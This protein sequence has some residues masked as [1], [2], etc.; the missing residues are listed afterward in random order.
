M[1]EAA[2]ALIDAESG[3]HQLATVVDGERLLVDPADIED[4]TGWVLK[5]EGLCR[6]DVCVPVREPQA[7][8]VDGRIDLLGLASAVRVPLVVDVDERVV[9]IGHPDAAGA[10][11]L[12]TAPDFELPD[13]D[14]NPVRLSSLG[15]GKKKILVT[16][17]SWCGCRHDLPAWEE[18]RRELEPEGLEIVSVA[19]DD[20]AD[21]ARTYVEMA[22]PAPQFRV[23][24]DRELL[25]GDLYG[26]VNVPSVVWI[27]ER[28]NV[29]RRPVIAPGDDQW[30]DFT[31]IDASVH[32]DQLRAWVS[33]G[34]V[35]FEACEAD[36]PSESELTARVERRVGAHLAREGRQDAA[37]RHFR[38]AMEL[39]PMDWTI[40]RGTLP[41][42][43]DDPFGQ[44]FFDF[45]QEWDEAGRPG[46]RS[47]DAV[48]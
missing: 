6:G 2:F 41:L 35:D 12:H 21:A 33:D 4:A 31:H 36:A 1:D 13:L 8:V 16:W 3:V 10:E 26:I 46:T 24:V 40:R 37:E 14:G 28:G 43:G 30:R 7:L 42:R 39:A 34:T 23:L 32:H 5:P 22:D 27:D 29:V 15:A 20:N 47:A 11:S 48:W 19:L 9:A 44:T 45:Y 25:L 18:L 17:A 38:R